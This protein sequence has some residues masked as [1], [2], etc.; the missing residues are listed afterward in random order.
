MAA[1]LFARRGL[2]GTQDDCDR[3]AGRGV[4]DVDRQEAAFIVMRVEQR[5]LLMA[6]DDVHRI[7]DVERH[8]VG[9]HRVACTVEIDQ[10]PISRISSRR[11]GA[12]SQRD[13]V[14]CEHRSRPLS[15]ADRRP[16]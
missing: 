8:G 12:F 6:V 5:K 4:I 16:D 7:V 1:D 9:R 13:T 15:G 3:T 11:L 14:G 2:A 10:Y